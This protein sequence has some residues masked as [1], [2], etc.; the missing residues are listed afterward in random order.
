MLYQLV[1]NTGT[2]RIVASR[3]TAT[4][5][6]DFVLGPDEA[7]IF[8]DVDLGDRPLA[9][10]QLDQDAGTVVP[11]GDW[12]P[13]EPGVRLELTVATAAR[14]PIDDAPELPADGVSEATVT[15]QKQVTESGRALTGAQ[16]RNLL[17]IRTTAGTLSVRQVALSRGQASFKLR[18]STET[19]IAEVRVSAEGIE[20]TA[21]ARIEFAPL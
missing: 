2:G 6:E 13:P 19:V 7:V 17:T 8:T 16:H 3:P 21:S 1:Y 10:F 18:S 9:G 20:Q 15:V 5:R 11:R 4:P 12:S 14:S